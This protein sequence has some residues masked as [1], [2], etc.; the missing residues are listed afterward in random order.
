[1]LLVGDI[2]GTKT[3]LALFEEDKSKTPRFEKKYPSQDYPE[4]IEILRV[5]HKESAVNSKE[6]AK[7]C[8]GVAGPV[9]ENRCK[10]TNLPWVIDG[11]SLEKELKIPQVRIINDLEANAYGL[12]MLEAKEFHLIQ[13]GKQ[14]IGNQALIA[15]GTGLGE[16]CLAWNGKVHLPFGC[17]GGHC[18]FAPRD[19]LEMELLRY[20]KKQFGHV[21]YERVISGAGFYQLYR[22][23][24]DMQLEKED[25]EM[26]RKF[27]QEDPARVITTAAID[28][29][30]RIC[31]RAVRWFL[32]LYG[33]EAGNVALKFLS[34]GGFFIGGG[35]APRLINLFDQGDFVRSFLD[36][37]RFRSLLEEMTIK[38]VLNDDAALLGALRYAREFME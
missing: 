35:I 30:S 11:P 23:L 32:S 29:T 19:E 5:F 38:I 9:V 34:V 24:I 13:E 27:S 18:D 21:S 3:H 37:G 4:F 6:I 7:A 10:T 25:P 33:A 26:R 28:G 17:E 12:K 36:K 8:F 20:L 16:A 14:K 1:M 31:T 15:A 22:F 2:G